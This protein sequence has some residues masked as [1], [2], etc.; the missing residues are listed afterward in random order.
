MK[1]RFVIIATFQYSHEAQVLASKLESLG[2]QVF[3]DDEFTVDVDPFVSNAIG[4]VKLKVALENKEEA[5]N[6]IAESHPEVL[7]HEISCPNCQSDVLK[8]TL[9]LSN[10]LKQLFPFSNT[11]N[12]TCG[13]CKF[14]FNSS[15][16]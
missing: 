10:I 1:D 9:N 13:N 6:I 14:Q 16:L 11:R 2:V 8:L 3:L 5:R 7:T 15:R 4:G 12:Y